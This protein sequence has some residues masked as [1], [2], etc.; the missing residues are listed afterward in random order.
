MTKRPKLKLLLSALLSTLLAMNSAVVIAKDE[1]STK[2]GGSTMKKYMLA[3]PVIP[4]VLAIAALFIY[5]QSGSVSAVN[6][7]NSVVTNEKSVA[8]ICEDD[9]V[10]NR[11]VTSLCEREADFSSPKKTLSCGGTFTCENDKDLQKQNIGVIDCYQR[12][13]KIK[14]EKIKF[15]DLQSENR[16]EVKKK[17]ENCVMTIVLYNIGDDTDKGLNGITYKN[18]GLKSTIYDC[19]T[20]IHSCINFLINSNWN[21][22]FMAISYNG[23]EYD[24]GLESIGERKDKVYEHLVRLERSLGIDNR[25]NTRVDSLHPLRTLEGV[26]IAIWWTDKSVVESDDEPKSSNNKRYKFCSEFCSIL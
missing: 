18:A 8:V 26:T 22:C 25:W 7:K 20:M 2:T 9:A 16:D 4:V 21:Q 1:K 17:I 12:K 10:M 13:Y 19:P 5:T 15:S 11:Y 14:F 23:K 24:K 3:A 6:N